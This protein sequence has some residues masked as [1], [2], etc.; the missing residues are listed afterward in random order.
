MSKRFEGI[1]WG[2]GIMWAIELLLL[3]GMQQFGLVSWDDSQVVGEFLA[4]DIT[5]LALAVM[6]GAAIVLTVTSM[7]V[8][9]WEDFKCLRR[10]RHTT[11]K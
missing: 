7:S 9:I 3:V 11:A 1:L 4:L 5:L 6:I 8:S 2:I 10:V